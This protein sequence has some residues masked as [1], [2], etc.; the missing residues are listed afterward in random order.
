MD[1]Q[2][3]MMVG[4][5]GGI[6][7]GKTTVTQIFLSLA[8]EVIDSDKITRKLMEKN[9][10]AYHQILARFGERILQTDGSIHRPKLRSIIFDSIEDRRWLESLLHPLVKEEILILRKKLPKGKYVIVEIPLLIEANFQ[11]AVDRVLV[12]DC[13]EATQIERVIR[14]DAVP[15]NILQSILKSQSTREARLKEAHDVI[16]NEGNKTELKAKVEGLHHYYQQ[17]TSNYS[18]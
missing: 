18:N 8:V 12:V 11:D 9:T 16:V 2:N 6:G 14:R 17:L 15:E 10:A 4:L 7:S 13:N 5:T 3:N 1:R